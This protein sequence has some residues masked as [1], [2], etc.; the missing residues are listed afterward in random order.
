MSDHDWELNRKTT[1]YWNSMWV[2]TKCG[3]VSGSIDPDW[4]PSSEVRYH[5]ICDDELLVKRVLDE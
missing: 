5:M 4:N 2:C 1:K 3:M